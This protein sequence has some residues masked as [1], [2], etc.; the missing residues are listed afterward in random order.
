MLV[1]LLLAMLPLTMAWPDSTV[2]VATKNWSPLV[3]RPCQDSESSGGTGCLNQMC[4]SFQFANATVRWQIL[5]I[6]S[7]SEN[8]TVIS[9]SAPIFHTSTFYAI[10]VNQTRVS[11]FGMCDDFNDFNSCSQ[12]PVIVW[13]SAAASRWGLVFQPFDPTRC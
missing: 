8:T 9:E 7:I 11:D 2:I 3:V 5:L 13:N 12:N 6:P 4:Q 10:D 1:L